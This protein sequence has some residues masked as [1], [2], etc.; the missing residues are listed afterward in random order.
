MVA[1]YS[2]EDRLPAPV[3]TFGTLE[4][5]TGLNGETGPE[6]PGAASPAGRR[7]RPGAGRARVR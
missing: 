1:G 5:V 3:M 2:Y 4:D 7:G 6:A